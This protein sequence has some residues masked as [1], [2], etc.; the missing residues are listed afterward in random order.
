MGR[1]VWG[2]GA[3]AWKEWTYFY[4]EEVLGR[5]V[6]LFEALLARIWH[7]LHDCKGWAQGAQTGIGVVGCCFELL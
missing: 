5:A 4:L 1:E 3:G 2:E 6:D 7:G